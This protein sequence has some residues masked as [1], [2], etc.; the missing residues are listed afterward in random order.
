VAFFTP[1]F[2][3]RAFIATQM[4]AWTCC[5]SQPSSSAS[6][7]VSFSTKRYAAAVGLSVL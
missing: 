4:A 1:A 3:V 5:G 7:L 2:S 6:L